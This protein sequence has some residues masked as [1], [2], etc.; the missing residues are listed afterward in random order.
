VQRQDIT[1]PTDDGRQLRRRAFGESL[2]IGLAGLLAVGAGVLG[3]WLFATN[4]IREN[5]R[6]HLV[7]L[8][9]AAAL[10]V[11]PVLHARIRDP[12]QRNGPEYNQV[13]APLRLL[14]GASDDIRYIFTAVLDGDA[15]HYV[16]DAAEPGDHDGDGVDDQVGV[17]EQSSNDEP[18]MMAALRG[19]LR[20]DAASTKVPYSGRWGSFMTGYAPIFDAAHRQI[21]VVG[22]DVNADVYVARLAQA[23]RR[24]LLGLLP[25]MLLVLALAVIYY[26]QRERGLAATVGL[27]LEQARLR[28]SE[29]SFRS[30]FELSPVGIAMN[31][32]ASG[33]FL[34]VNDALLQ[35][36]GHSREELLAMTY[37][38]ITPPD[39][40]AEE[41]V[42]I[43]SMTRTRRYGPYEKEYLRKDGSRYP[44]LLSGISL[45]D[46]QGRDVIWSIVQDISQR[47]AFESELADAARRDKLTGL[48]NRTQFMERLQQLV[49]RC[50]GGERLLFGV[51]FL[52]FDRFKMVNDT[53]GHDAG[54]ELLR[55][56]GQRLR[57][58]LRGGEDGAVENR[59][60]LIARFGGDEFLVLLTD[61]SSS[62]V[63]ERV[64]ERLLNALAPAYTILGRDVH[65]T[66][67]IGIVTS[68]QCLES[69]DAIVR[70]ADVAMY[71]AKRDGRACSVVFNESMHVRLTRHVTIESGLRKA[72]GTSQLSL[73]YQPIV[74]LETGHTVSVEALLRWNHPVLGEI[75]PSEFVPVA[76]ESGLIVALG[77]WVLHEACLM[78]ADWRSRDP[79]SAPQSVSV[80]IS[81]AELALGQ[82]LL[83]R[84]RETLASTGLPAECLQLEVTEREV[85]RDP[86]ASSSLMHDMRRLGVRLAMD[87]FGT[88]T[89]S[90]GCLH[91]YPFDV[92]K[93]DRSFVRDLAVNP[94]VLAVVHATLM[95]VENLGKGSVAEGVENAAQ[96][97]VLQSLGCRHAQG[98]FFSRPLSASL[99]YRAASVEPIAI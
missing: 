64:A 68:E 63:A 8:A 48:A 94:D 69:A 15:I 80:N 3:L 82:R 89:S 93:I 39:Y 9:R 91:D 44:V 29:S 13:V 96:V 66:A 37:W 74:E 47:K 67:S 41:Q 45:T 61:L 38:D 59:G 50:K 71:E 52:D 20:G 16:L 58:S 4:A 23:R 5:Y 79:A 21:G 62:H 43:D 70:N 12:A 86:H 27:A 75:S 99:L 32:L 95:L 28:D 72:L 49:A 33:R 31:D 54:D 83:G 77:Q 36:S 87:D 60:T 17:W 53:L 76:E 81:R 97:A 56:I 57:T 6:H 11:D 65:S 25:S 46:A 55:Q 90:L 24:A 92:I 88:G 18:V 85:M 84:V 1:A 19:E 2:L 51:L 40:A 7:T 98:Y 10:Q 42:Q 14:R 73:V 30:L 34:Q 26:R 35:S 78:L 22:V